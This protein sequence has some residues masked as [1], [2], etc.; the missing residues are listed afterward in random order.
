MKSLSSVCQSVFSLSFLKIG[1]LAFSDIVDDDSWP[2]NLVTDGAR[3]LKKSFDG[4]NLA[5]MG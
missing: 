1:S 3:F 5:Q 2:R 4:R